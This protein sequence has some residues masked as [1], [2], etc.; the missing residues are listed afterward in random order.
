MFFFSALLYKKLLEKKLD[1]KTE[2]IVNSLYLQFQ[3]QNKEIYDDDLFDNEEEKNFLEYLKTNLL[4][5]IKFDY[6]EKPYF[7]LNTKDSLY[8]L[9]YIKNWKLIWKIF[10]Y[11]KI[12]RKIRTMKI[13]YL[14][15]LNY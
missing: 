3:S 7:E 8:L 14:M 12:F 9:M 1:Y 6:Y 4:K 15:F 2:K 5:Q 13:I 10:L 11:K